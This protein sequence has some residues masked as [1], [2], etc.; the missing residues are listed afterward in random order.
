M[1]LNNE[2]RRQIRIAA[3]EKAGIGARR[4]AIKQRYADWA[5]A[6]RRTVVP[7][8]IDIRLAKAR[9]VLADLP[10]ELDVYV[11]S[12]KSQSVRANVA[13]MVRRF[14]WDGD[15]SYNESIPKRICPEEIVLQA[16]SVLAEQLD[17]IDRDADAL[18]KDQE[19][20]TVSINAVLCSVQTDAQLLKIWPEAIE[21]IPSAVKAAEPKLPALRIDE[22]NK[23]IGLNSVEQ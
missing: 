3:L 2:I 15:T 23:M 11:A 14:Y 17:K 20:L 21:F 4:I 16:G 1:R 12:R 10:E 7:D 8:N 5:E 19:Q 6:V 9:D 22:L 13:G 18:H